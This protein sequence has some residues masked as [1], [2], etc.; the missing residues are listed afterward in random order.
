MNPRLVVRAVIEPER[1]LATARSQLGEAAV[2]AASDDDAARA[3]EAGAEFLLV[4]DA[5]YG[6]SLADVVRRHGRRLRWIQAL[7]SG[8]DNMALHGVPRGVVVSNAGDAYAPAVATHAVALL[9]ALQRRIPAAI[10]AQREARWD[11]GIGA[12]ATVPLGRRAVVLGLGPIGQEICRLL[13]AFG[14]RVVAVTRTGAPSQRVETRSFAHFADA[15]AEADALVL[16]APLNEAT[17]HVIS[18]ELLERCKPG[19]LLVNI[20][21]GGLIDEPALVAALQQGRMAGAALDVAQ[22]E[23]L[24]ATDA[25]W[26][27]PNLLLTPHVAGAAED[28]SI[29]RLCAVVGTNLSR[30]L[31]GA[32]PLH[33][34]VP[35]A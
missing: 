23:P 24:P 14:M 25:L 26:H 31:A 34:V 27:A 6:A 29:A 9:L 16:A 3:L 19:L 35:P 7:T 32:L 12:T 20:G 8:T 13:A 18:A 22:R 2:G 11:R 33:I 30:V 21:R 5:A 17:R 15:A 28:V 1:V 4:S 10:A